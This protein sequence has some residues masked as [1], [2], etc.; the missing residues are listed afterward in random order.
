MQERDNASEARR[1][2]QASLRAASQ[3]PTAQSAQSIERYS[4]QIIVAGG[5]AQERLSAARIVMAGDAADVG[6][7]LDYLAG[8]G[9]GRINLRLTGDRASRERLVAYARDLNRDVSVEAEVPLD[10]QSTAALFSI[11]GSTQ[12][13]AVARTL[14][15][16]ARE[17]PAIVVRLDRRARI[18]IIPAPPDAAAAELKLFAPFSHRHGNAAF[19]AMVATTELLKLLISDQPLSNASVI[20]FDGY[21]TRVVST[22]S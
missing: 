9:V 21:R 16:D 6:P 19:V 20:E 17:S 12:A 10:P 13:L 5:I 15:T 11:I 7:V 1:S 8:A 3:I 22:P 2:E 4:R 18:A 14:C